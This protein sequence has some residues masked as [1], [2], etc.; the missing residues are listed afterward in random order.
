LPADLNRALQEDFVKLILV[1]P[2][3]DARPIGDIRRDESRNDHQPRI[4]QESRY[5]SCPSQ[6]LCAIR[7]TESQIAAQAATQTVSIKYKASEARL[8]QFS[9]QQTSQSSF[10]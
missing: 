1:K 9:V 10:T 8:R 2:A 6:V 7:G 5:L 4:D 3:A